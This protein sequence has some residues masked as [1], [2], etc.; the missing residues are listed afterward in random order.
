MKKVSFWKLIIVGLIFVYP[1][2][3]LKEI[4][5]ETMGIPEKFGPIL[6]FWISLI[7]TSTFMILGY[8][9]QWRI[10]TQNKE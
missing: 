6:T 7:A 1:S 2:A 3:L 10:L 5:S 4:L 9:L 8:K